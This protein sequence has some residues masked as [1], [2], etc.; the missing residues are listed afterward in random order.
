MRYIAVL[1]ILFSV[2]L[3]VYAQNRIDSTAK[4]LAD[5]EAQWVLSSLNNDHPWLEK[6]F[7]GQLEVHPENTIASLR[8]RSILS[9]IDPTLQPDQFKVRISGRIDL[10]SNDKSKDRSFE[11]LDTFNRNNGKWHVIAT[12]LSGTSTAGTRNVDAITRQ[13]TELEN[14][15]A[16]A[17]VNNYRSIFDKII[18]PEFVATDAKGVVHN[19][20]KWLADWTNADEKR[21]QNVEMSVNA[22]A[23]NVAVVTGLYV[24]IEQENG[25][26]V[27][28]HDRFTHTW[29]QRAG[30][31]QCISSH[32]TRLQ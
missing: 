12:H 9:L 32:V 2:C 14:V 4:N 31:W 6:F 1:L 30:Q 16:Q 11:F 7:S 8:T 29:L 17:G 5:F 27:T 13:I 24:T 23:D 19:R 21:A 28:H 15:W 10:L 22:V 20:S 3:N 18:A 26:E 25:H